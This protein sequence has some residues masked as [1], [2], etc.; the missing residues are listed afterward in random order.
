[1]FEREFYYTLELGCSLQEWVFRVRPWAPSDGLPARS[2][3]GDISLVGELFDKN[4]ELL[5]D[6]SGRPI[7]IYGNTESALRFQAE[8]KLRRLF[9]QEPRPSKVK[10]LCL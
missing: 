9:L 6:R 3:R 1:M 4:G 2:C 5:T 7:L 8:E 10:C